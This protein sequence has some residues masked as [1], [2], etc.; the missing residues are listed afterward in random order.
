MDK[1]AMVLALVGGFLV[2]SLVGLLVVLGIATRHADHEVVALKSE[3]EAL[4]AALALF[5]GHDGRGHGRPN[6]L[7]TFNTDVNLPQVS[8]EAFVDPMAS[9]IGDVIVGHEV[10]VAPFASIRG[11]EGQPIALGDDTNVQDGVVIHA[12]ETVE[13]GIPVPNR[14]F[15]VNGRAYAVYIGKRVSLA[16]QSQVHG[17]ARIDDN[18]FIGMQALVFK[19][20]VGAGAVVEPGAKLI[21]VSVPAGRYVPA[22]SVITDQAAA[23]KL[24]LIT[25][26]YPFRTLNDA[27]VHVNSSFAKGY[28][29][30]AESEA[31]A[32]KAEEA[33]GGKEAKVAVAPEHH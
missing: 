33:T 18:V 26:D 22:G 14:T 7:T 13:A 6:V 16:H 1:K 11:D 32:K 29:A 23:D 2:T 21:G 3:V 12:L 8:A 20:S 19:S 9:V 28:A 31:E 17:P 10:Y 5:P 24:P 25:P 4:K 30:S 15:E 27:V